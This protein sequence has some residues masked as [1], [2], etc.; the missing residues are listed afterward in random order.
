MSEQ[1][2]PDPKKGVDPLREKARNAVEGLRDTAGLPPLEGMENA[3]WELY[4]GKGDTRPAPQE[5]IPKLA[6]F[7][8][9]SKKLFNR[10][11]RLVTINEVTGE[12]EPMTPHQLVTWVPNTVGI[13]THNGRKT[14]QETGK[15]RFAI[16]AL[17]V[18]QAT[19][20]LASQEFKTMMP[21]IRDV[22]LVPMPVW[23]DKLDERGEERRKGFR[24]IEW[25]QPGYD[26][27]T[28]S[29]TIH[30]C[31]HIDHSWDG[32]EAAEW[33]WK[34]YRTFDWADKDKDMRSNRMA[35]HVA[36]QVTCLARYLF[37]G[38]APVFMYNSNL[39]GS[40]K[41]ALISAALRP[42]F[43]VIGP[44][45][46]D[47]SDRAELLKTLN[48]KAESGDAY[49][50]GDEMPE[51]REINNQHLARWTT[52]TIWEKRGMGQDSKITK[53]DITKMITIFAVNRGR[54]NRN[55][56]RR[57]LQADLH[58]HQEAR[59]RKLPEGAT[60][61]DERFFSK[62]ENVDK[63]LSATA[64]LI[65]LWDE[66]NRPASS[67]GP[68]PSFEGWSEIVPA[69]VQ[70]AQLGRPLAPFE[71]PGAGDDDS[72]QMNKLAKGVIDSFCFELVQVP[73]SNE[74]TKRVLDSATVTMREIVSTAR[75][76]G[77]FT[78]RLGTTEQVRDMLNERNRFKWKDVE[79][80]VQSDLMGG[81]ASIRLREPTEPEKLRQAAEFLDSSGDMSGSAWGKFFRKMAMDERYFTSSCGVVFQFGERG[82]SK[83]S[84]FV[85]RRVG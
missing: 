43:R 64:A 81:Q 33:L 2:K 71:A 22:N 80:E 27:Q 40:G 32:M 68:L 41:G 18:E 48:T 69:I 61:L 54:L 55:I 21:E 66:C 30:G 65:R 76:L 25:L 62:Q 16:S 17:S 19:L 46:I 47:P 36:L 53:S 84:R 3:G 10:G 20:A 44:S 4:V 79:E 23:R 8:R 1:P 42:V 59:E 52:A 7:L 11:G 63:L 38:K 70:G 74:R 75:N 29:F 57:T 60:R 58:P 14:D 13:V 24:K 82:A 26:A 85:L 35:V 12:M 67:D 39:E 56:A 49:V 77:L 50:F 28:K 73:G 6:D 31:P 15:E 78:D 45:T 83:A 9:R 37:D 34:L 72:R 51:D 5:M